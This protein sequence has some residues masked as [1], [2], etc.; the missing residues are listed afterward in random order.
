MVALMRRVDYAFPCSWPTDFFHRIVSLFRNGGSG[1]CDR[2]IPVSFAV[3]A[4]IP[5]KAGRR[6]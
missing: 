6:A 2:R 5:R 4:R 3:L 1:G